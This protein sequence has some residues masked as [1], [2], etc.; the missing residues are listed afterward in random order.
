MNASQARAAMH[1]LMKQIGH[2]ILWGA[3][4]AGA[5]AYALRDFEVKNVDYRGFS[6]SDEVYTAILRAAYDFYRL[7]SVRSA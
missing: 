7:G 4:P 3:S 6:F 2:G 1:Q 5:V